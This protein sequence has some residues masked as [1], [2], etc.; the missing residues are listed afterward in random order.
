MTPRQ[1]AASWTALPVVMVRQ[2]GF[3]VDLLEPL[4]DSTV[5]SRMVRLRTAEATARRAAGELRDQLR[6]AGGPVSATVAARIGMLAPVPDSVAGSR[7]YREA[8]A[9]LQGEWREFAELHRAWLAQGRRSVVDA[10]RADPALREVLLLSNDAHYPRFARWLAEPDVDPTSRTYRRMADL[11]CRYLQR[12]TAKNDTTA[13]FGPISVALLGTEP[14]LHWSDR[15]AGRRVDFFTHWAAEA[16]GRRFASQAPLRDQVRPR[17]SPLALLDGRRLRQYAPTTSSGLISDW[18]FDQTDDVVLDPEQTWLLGRCDGERTLAELRAEWPGGDLDGVLADL[19]A[20]GHL[21]AHFEIPVG[22]P[23]PLAALRAA[24][25]SPATSP[26]AS[27]AHGLLDTFGKLLAEFGAA[28][29]GRRAPVLEQMKLAFTEATGAPAHRGEGRIYADRSLVYEEC[30]SRAADFTFGPDL[31]RLLTEDLV[32]AYQIALAGSRA[33]MLAERA[34]LAEWV[35]GRFGAGRDVA[36]PDFYAAHVEDRALL[37]ERSRPVDEQVAQ[38]ERHLVG[39]LLADADLDARAVEVPAER[40]AALVAG[41]PTVPSAV[42]NPDIMLAA[43]SADAVADGD[44]Q[45]VVG[46]CHA[47]RELLAHSSLS[48]LLA[49]RAPELADLVHAA[50]GGLLDS[51]EVLCDLVRSHPNKTAVQLRFPCPDI[52]ITG[53]SAKP[54]SQVIQPDQLYLRAADGQIDLYAR[55]VPHRLRLL[56]TPAGGRSI[57]RDPLTPFSFPRHFGGIGIPSA[58]PHVPRIT[59]GRLVLRRESWRV[60]ADQLWRPTAVAGISGDP[61]EFRAV[62][63]LRERLGLPR[64]VFARLPGEPKPIYLDLDS[65]M[66]VRQVCRIA[67]QTDGVVELSEMLPGPSQL[68]LHLDGQRYTTE[69]R[70]A[71]FSGSLRTTEN[72]DRS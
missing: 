60:P 61:A 32:P 48:P 41:L 34:L 71:V 12:V 55:G 31:A 72:G 4:A 21:V 1:D 5:T 46:E 65:A 28:E 54:R 24:L 56:T 26:A 44:Y 58:L 64:H 51:D 38:L 25:P 39:T 30:H 27:S 68:W 43:S 6:A 42:C 62:Q 67:R 17:R 53:R 45:V 49:E 10:F 23:D 16:L 33:R 66:L 13:H 11:L 18:R 19:A 40:L 47:V 15:K 3:P 36:L 52:E 63:D 70:Y 7:R 59:S 35:S 57:R 20:R 9:Q 14:G 22:E 50:Y 2:A 69:L 8:V 37:A 29:Y